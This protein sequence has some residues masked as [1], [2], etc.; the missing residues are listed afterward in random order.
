MISTDNGTTVDHA[1]YVDDVLAET[2][3][4]VGPLAQYSV[5][6]LGSGLGNSGLGAYFDNV[7]LEFV[8]AASVPEANAFGAVA[9]ITAISLGAA[10]LRKKREDQAGE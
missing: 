7:R 6:R 4:D 9:L 2:V 1:Y 8:Q 10:W 5:M 3:S